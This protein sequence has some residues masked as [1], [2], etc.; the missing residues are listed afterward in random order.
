MFF[1]PPD[2]FSLV[3]LISMDPSRLNCCPPFAIRPRFGTPAV[4]DEDGHD[5]DGDGVEDDGD[6]VGDEGEEGVSCHAR[7]F[8]DFT[9]R[10]A[11]L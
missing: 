6:G 7:W 11:S 8:L 1:P 10:S 5:G 2:S 4:A 3:S 9:S